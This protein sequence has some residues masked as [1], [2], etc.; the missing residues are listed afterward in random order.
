MRPPLPHSDITTGHGRVTAFPAAAVPIFSLLSGVIWL[1]LDQSVGYTG[2]SKPGHN[3]VTVAQ[4]L[5]G[6]VDP[7]T[8]CVVTV[9]ALMIIVLIHRIVYRKASIRT[10][11]VDGSSTSKD[12]F[13]PCRPDGTILESNI[14]PMS[15]SEIVLAIT[16][17]ITASKKVL[18]VPN[19]SGHDQAGTPQHPQGDGNERDRAAGGNPTVASDGLH[20]DAAE[21]ASDWIWEIDTDLCLTFVSKRFGDASGIPWA[22]VSGQRLDHLVTLGFNA[23]GMFELYETIGARRIFQRVIYSVL[24]ED[25]STRFW[26]LSGK[27]FF[28][29]ETGAFAGYR[30]SG[31]DVT[32]TIEREEELNAARLRAEAAEQEAQQMRARLVDAI[33]AIPEGFVLHD[34]DDRLVL[35]NARFREIYGLPVEAMMPG[36]R[37]E[38]ALRYSAQNGSYALPEGQDIETWIAERLSS[39]RALNGNHFEQRLANGRWLQVDERRTSD[40]GTVGILVDVTEARHL[41]AIE[42]D[43]E[44]TT[45]ELQAARLMQISLLPSIRL[46]KEIMASS[47]L[48]IASRSASCSELG[49]DLWGLSALDHGLIG[50]YT[51]DF[52]GHGTTAALNT[53]RLHA[54]IHELRAVQHEPVLFLKELNIRLTELLPP[55]AYATMFY[56][57]ID[58]AANCIRYA[59]AG[60]P[61][62]IIRCGLDSPLISID[63]CGVPLGITASA[64]Y[65]CSAVKFAPGGMLFL[66]SDM[67]TD[68]VDPQGHRTGEAGAFK[69]I[70]SCATEP[71]AEAMVDRICAPFLNDPLVPLSD[72]LTAVCI[73]RAPDR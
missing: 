29:S 19:G 68:C 67:L 71:T 32:A 15:T 16:D 39:H 6:F 70:Q 38:D 73:M 12:R 28:N 64:E 36:A 56:G 51:V 35:C 58:L 31:T 27:P 8:V 9:L 50:F 2:R 46:Q 10:H 23:G 41:E 44:R 59:A 72:D 45:A 26:R 11:A 18:S 3:G 4:H 53:F 24:L 17:P 49:G 47:G 42:R 65:V 30:G 43:Q 21:V 52:A 13:E 40:G 5:T 20:R 57:V 1:V 33:N 69:I 25:G 34:A 14:I 7:A 54:L 63:S 66:Y 55:G 61:P 22:K 37:F 60:S 48:D 62:P